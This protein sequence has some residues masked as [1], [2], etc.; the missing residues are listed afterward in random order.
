MGVALWIVIIVIA[1][2]AGLSFV[3]AYIITHGKR[4]TLDESWE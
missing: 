2:V 1:I 3:F 4:Q